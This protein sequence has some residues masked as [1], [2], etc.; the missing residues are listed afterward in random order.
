MATSQVTPPEGFTFN[1][2]E[3][4]P[5]WVRRFERFRFATELDSKGEEKQVN[6]LLYT[7]GDLAE[8]ILHMFNLSETDKKKYEVVKQKFDSYFGKKR[9]VIFERAKFNRRKQEEGESVDDFVTSVHALAEH[10]GFAGLRDELIR[11]R[12]VVGLRDVSLSE[13]LQ[14]D[15]DLTLEKTVTMVRQSEM[16]KK[17]QVLLRREVETEE[18]IDRVHSKAKPEDREVRPRKA[19][20]YTPGAGR[21]SEY[22]GKCSYCGRT[23]GHSYEHCPAREAICHKCKRRGHWKEMCRTRTASSVQAVFIDTLGDTNLDKSPWRQ[24]L[25][26]NGHQIHFKLDTGADVTVIPLSVYKQLKNTTLRYPEKILY[27]PG[28]QKLL[29]RGCFLG[30]L[31]LGRKEVKQ[32]IYVLPELQVPL[33]GRP[34]IESLSLLQRVNF[35]G[36]TAVQQKYPKLF[37][38]LGIMGSEYKI[39]MKEGATPFAITT[40]RR[41]ATPLLPKVKAEL[42][43][44]EELGV[45]SSVE[46]PTNWCA[47]MVVVPKANGDIRICVDL[48]KLNANVCRENHPLPVVD[49]ILTQL[50]GA[51]LFSKL[52]ANSGFWQIPLAR[53]SALLTTFITPFGRFCFN[54]LPFGITSAPELFQ[55]RMSSI[56]GGM[57][58]VVCL[59][60]DILVFGKTRV[61]HDRRLDQVL[62]CLLS[63]GLTLNA[64]KCEFSKTEIRFLGH[65]V[66]NKGISPDPEKMKAITL[67]PEPKDVGDIR[68]F[69]G[70]IN[71]LST[72]S[73]HTAHETKPLRDLLS[74]KNLWV[75]GTDQQRAFQKIKKLLSNSPLLALYDPNLPTVVSADASSF[76][77]GG[78]LLQKQRDSKVLPVCYIS[79]AMTSTEQR[80]AQI[81]KEALA[82]TWAC[83]RFSDYLLGLKFHLETDHK[84]LVPLLSTKNLEELPI[85]VQRFRLRLMRFKFSISHVPGKNLTIADA[86]SRAPVTQPSEEEKAQHNDIEAFVHW[87]IQGIPAT[88]KK[89]NQ[90][91]Q[92][93]K[94]DSVCRQIAVYSYRGWPEKKDV[95]EAVKPYFSVAGELSIEKGL[96]LRGS[97]IVVPESLRTEILNKIHGAHQGITKCRERARQ[98]VWW[99]NISKDLEKLV[100]NCPQCIKHQSQQVEPLIPTQLPSLP[101]QRVGAD[102]F[103]WK[104]DNYLLIVD[105]YSRF[106]EI[107][108]LDRMTAEE[109]ISRTKSIFARHG[110]PEEFISDNGPQFSSHSFLKFSQEYGFDHITSSP[111]FPQSNGAAE[112]AVKTIKTMWKKTSDPCLA[113]LSYRAT[114]LQNGYSPAE[115]LMSRKLRTTV[116]IIEQERVPKVPEKSVVKEM[117]SQAKGLQK[118][119]FDHRHRA[120][121]LPELNPGDKVWIAD[122][123]I[124]GNV[125]KRVA[126]RSYIINTTIG[127][128]R[129]NRRFLTLVKRQTKDRTYSSQSLNISEESELWGTV[130]QQEPEP[131]SS[132]A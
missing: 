95:P 86:L 4:W 84:P 10:C 34:A 123:K 27:G 55:K 110:I 36:V 24:S 56:L 114:P 12:I 74:K 38:G 130:V 99:P 105:Y 126:P 79:R 119:N 40:P 26:L 5:K 120:V 96:L 103:H 51:Q 11:D 106:I 62:K 116:P 3:E 76:G 109:V 118:N 54:R 75:W 47:G 58:G 17:Q 20:G 45:I 31:R 8:D 83:E 124:E 97:R 35:V 90:I 112:R 127:E 104:G 73:P 91:R 125:V 37:E 66:S 42:K 102:I 87:I 13:K 23:P 132:C 39:R 101:W 30:T 128:Y 92:C 15:P 64:G 131:E 52:D 78:V 53:E 33:L 71:Q 88:D 29:V 46:E 25:S 57:D 49:Q 70:I 77:L 7:M 85:R 32:E 98:S 60:D 68:R 9:N 21:G 129:R 65:V 61:E 115:L 14:L 72:F 44:M 117:E 108:H 43:R 100:K 93:Q 19:Q 28:N 69:L 63:A 6:M 16:V 22:R 50:T 121:E 107:A 80:Y 81:E 111:L 48:T 89:L 113:L 122:R 1:Q 82:L 41:V 2:P 59:I 94:T 18:Q 67:F